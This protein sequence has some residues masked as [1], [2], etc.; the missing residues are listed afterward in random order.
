MTISPLHKTVY[1]QMSVSIYPDNDTMGRAAAEAAADVINQAV[2]ERGVANVVLATGNSQ[3]TFLHSLRE[4][5]G[6]HWAAVNVFHL[7]QYLNLPP[8]HPASFPLFLRRHLLEHVP[9]AAFYPVPGNASD[10]EAACRGYALL[11]RAHPADLCCLG[12]G[13]NGHLA[14][15]DPPVANFDDSLWVKVVKLEEASRRQ[16]VGEGHF[17]SLDKVPTH[18]ITMTIPALRAAKEMLCIVP[19]KRKAE[20]VRKALLGPI[21]TACP[22][23]I[24]R[25][26]PHAR[27]FL[28]RESA[29]TIL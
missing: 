18:A 26:T 9:V 25:Q 6:V 11:L 3:L 24:L 8:G 17:G 5:P 22:A 29:G 15:N 19:E 20:A 7:D 12:I 1:G 21:S 27:L 13:E 10:V 4:L 16:Q 2:A 14:F 23:S 28:D